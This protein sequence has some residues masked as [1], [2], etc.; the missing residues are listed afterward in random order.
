MSQSLITSVCQSFTVKLKNNQDESGCLLAKINLHR[1][2]YFR[3]KGK[4][5][6]QMEFKVKH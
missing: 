2:I 1:D 5:E 3:V 4:K 6:L